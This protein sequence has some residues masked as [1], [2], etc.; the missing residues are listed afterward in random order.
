MAV[1]KAH[2]WGC[3]RFFTSE[4]VT[5]EPAIATFKDAVAPG[6]KTRLRHP[7]EMLGNPLAC[8]PRTQLA[9]AAQGSHKTKG[10]TVKQIANEVHNKV[11][12]QQNKFTL[13]SLA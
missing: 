3:R 7:T 4:L 8:T 13:W 6:L 11:S 9:T 5:I 1:G 2:L 10:P 12:T